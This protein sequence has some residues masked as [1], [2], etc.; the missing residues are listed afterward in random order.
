MCE[1]KNK[2]QKL[3]DRMTRSQYIA[4]KDFIVVTINVFRQLKTNLIKEVKKYMMSMLY[5]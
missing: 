4:G 1:R 5:Q 3:P 2:Q